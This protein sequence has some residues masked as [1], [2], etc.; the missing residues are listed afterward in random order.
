MASMAIDMAHPLPI[1]KP[2]ATR[3][4]QKRIRLRGVRPVDDSAKK[5]P[6]YRRQPVLKPIDA[7]DRLLERAHKNELL[8]ETAITDDTVLSP[9]E[10]WA[11]PGGVAYSECSEDALTRRLDEERRV[12]DERHHILLGIIEYEYCS[13]LHEL[14][15]IRNECDSYSQA[16]AELE[17][18]R[19][20]EGSFFELYEID[21][22]IEQLTLKRDL[23]HCEVEILGTYQP[24]A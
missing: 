7:R 24:A 8:Q 20:Q 13:R 16:I 19:S 18:E 4:R 5:Q 11:D 14:P 6:W 2:R 9:E 23:L 12:I 22:Q 10:F 15:E 21:K 1:A 17:I 3:R